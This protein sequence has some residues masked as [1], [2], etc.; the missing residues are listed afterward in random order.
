MIELFNCDTRLST[1]SA[2]N[3]GFLEMSLALIS[4]N[5]P[6]HNPMTKML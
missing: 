2:F 1:L 3:V 5:S 4:A 6:I